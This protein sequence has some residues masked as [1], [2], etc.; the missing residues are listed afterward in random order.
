MAPSLAGVEGEGGVDDFRV[1]AHNLVQRVS[2]VGSSRNR[3]ADPMK[4][5]SDRALIVLD[6]TVE[7][8]SAVPA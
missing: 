1:A 3:S 2:L 5:S 4:S 7:Q 8:V 6:M